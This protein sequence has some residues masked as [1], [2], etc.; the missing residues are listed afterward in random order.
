[1]IYLTN[2]D[3]EIESISRTLNDCI[4]LDSNIKKVN[5]DIDLCSFYETKSK[6]IVNSLRDLVSLYDDTNKR[7]KRK[8]NE[9]MSLTLKFFDLYPPETEI[10]LLTYKKF[11]IKRTSTDA[12]LILLNKRDDVKNRI[13]R[14][15]NKV[16]QGIFNKML[17]QLVNDN[18]DL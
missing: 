14:P 7:D 6:L 9:I 15:A 17:S 3:D 13:S 4:R 2:F 1:M 18:F 11:K 16:Y 8:L 12:F 10:T 5:K